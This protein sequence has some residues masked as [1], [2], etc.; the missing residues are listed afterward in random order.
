MNI[1]E[2]L[3]IDDGYCDSNNGFDNDDDDDDDDDDEDVKLFD[4]DRDGG[5]RWET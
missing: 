3:Y 5:A 4:M 1:F 2:P